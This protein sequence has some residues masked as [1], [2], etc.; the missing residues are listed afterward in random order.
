MGLEISARVKIEESW[1]SMLQEEFAKPYF[2]EIKHFLTAEKNKGKKVYPSGSLIFNAFDSTSF[3]RVKV[4]ILGQDPYHGKGQAH[5][6]CFSVQM[7]VKP[8]PSLVNIYKE[9]QADV[10]FNIPDHGYLQSWANQGVFLLNSILTVEAS[11]PAS[12]RK[13]GWETFTDSVIKKISEEK[14]HLV[15]LL[16]GRFAQNKSVL[17]DG[18]KHLILQAAHPSP[19][20]A[21]S[22]FFGCKHFSRANDYLQ[23]NGIEPVDW[24]L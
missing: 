21:H 7:G 9:L 14:E 22:G 5:G 8:P 15:F 17:I 23:Q 6:L 2:K 13:I 18:S 3:D 24:S 12:H 4:V 10:G 19:F 11:K 1:K 16:W 20:S